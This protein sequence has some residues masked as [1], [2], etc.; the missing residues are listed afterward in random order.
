MLVGCV[1]SHAA[2]F[3]AYEFV[4]RRLGADGPNHAPIA[5]ATSGAL[6]TTLH[7]GVL[8]PMDV[9]KQRLQLG[10]Y[11]SVGACVRAM[12]RAEGVRALWRSYPTTLALNIPYSGAAVMVNES[13]KRWLAPVLG[14]TTPAFL[15]AGALAGAVAGGA[16][17]PL[18]VIKTRLQCAAV[19]GSGAQCLAPACAG[20]AAREAAAA[21]AATSIS[22]VGAAAGS[23][24]TPLQRS[25]AA[26]SA[27]GAA[28]A[29]RAALLVANDVWR[30][31]GLRGFFRGAG[32][33]MAVH[34]PSQAIAWSAYEFCKRAL[35]NLDVHR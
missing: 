10:Y 18:D 29:F 6:A 35:V 19:V 26:L 24:A 5:A 17:T 33:R 9:V 34:A 23:C 1:P 20:S 11:T 28:G 32:A 14:A 31:E 21:T 8:T 22:S 4:K 30:V 3:S 2:Y 7:D 13:A 16:S 15:L 25:A 27:T 12:V